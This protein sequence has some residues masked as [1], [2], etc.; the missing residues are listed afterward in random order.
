LL[1]KMFVN[2]GINYSPERI[3]GLNYANP[4][5]SNLTLDG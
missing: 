3:I 4:I 5:V 2:K 1:N